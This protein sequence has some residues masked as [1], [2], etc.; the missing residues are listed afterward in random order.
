MFRS[1]DVDH[2]IVREKN[3]VDLITY[4]MFWEKIDVILR[5]EQT[6][7]FYYQNIS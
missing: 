2:I 6:M 4:E 1:R 5:N 3:I 7:N